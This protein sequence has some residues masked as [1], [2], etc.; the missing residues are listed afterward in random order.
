FEPNNNLTLPGRYHAQGWAK[1]CN[2]SKQHVG[3]WNHKNFKQCKNSCY[4][5]CLC[6]YKNQSHRCANCTSNCNRPS[7]RMSEFPKIYHFIYNKT[8][9]DEYNAQVANDLMED[10]IENN[11]SGNK[12]IVKHAQNFS[13]G[14]AGKSNLVQKLFWSELYPKFKNK[15]MVFLETVE[16]KEKSF[17]PF[18]AKY[19]FMTSRKSAKEAFNFG[20]RNIN[21]EISTQYKW[22]DNIEK[23]TTQLIFHKGLESDFY[24]ILWDLKYDKCEYTTEELK[25]IVQE[26]NKDKPGEV[27]V[28]NNQVYWY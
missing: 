18:L 21:D 24:G 5:S 27:I 26:L 25:K 8:K 10:L 20:Q 1:F 2:N 11:L 28:K 4:Q 19:I 17:V 13:Q 6:D 14:C 23:C 16:I 15:K 9:I 22:N 7:A 12:A 3:H